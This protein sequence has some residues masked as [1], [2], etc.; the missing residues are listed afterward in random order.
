MVVPNAFDTGHMIITMFLW[1]SFGYMSPVLNC[2]L[3]RMLVHNELSKHALGILAFY[4]LFTSLHMH[5]VS[6][7]PQLWA[8]S[9]ATY[10]VFLF[11]TKSKW[12][13]VIPALVLIMIDQA[14]SRQGDPRARVWLWLLAA[15]FIGFGVAHYAHTKWTEKGAQ[16]SWY[17]FFFKSGGCRDVA[18]NMFFQEQDAT[19]K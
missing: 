18:N 4:F 2:D 9:I 16:F 13:F 6:T 8:R 1:L 7:I 15:M 14:M 17:K 12:Y 11:M 3:Q 19:K 5:E 10:V